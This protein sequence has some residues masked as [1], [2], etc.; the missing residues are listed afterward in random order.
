[1]KLKEIAVQKDTKLLEQINTCLKKYDW[2][3]DF[4]VDSQITSSL[5]S[6]LFIL[7]VLEE[8]IRIYKEYARLENLIS[9]LR[10]KSDLLRT[11]LN[12]QNAEKIKEYELQLICLIDQWQRYQ[13]SDLHRLLENEL[14]NIRL[15]EWSFANR[16]QS[17]LEDG[18]D[19]DLDNFSFGVNKLQQQ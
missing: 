3:K 14:E 15:Q 18:Y 8:R 4:T 19:Y 2:G 5:E 7:P 11:D 16:L 1:M 13:S 9:T 12:S 6:I 10:S 17:M